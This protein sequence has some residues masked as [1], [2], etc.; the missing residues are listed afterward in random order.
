VATGTDRIER[1]GR[2]ARWLHAA[3]YLTTLAL[4]ATGLWLLGGQEGHPS[5][6]SRATGI[7]DTRLHIWL[8][9]ALTAVAALGLVAGVRAIPTFLRETFRYDRGDGRWFVR[10]PKAVF[11]G[12][13]GRHEGHWDPGQRIANV[14]M[15]VGLLLLTVTGVGLATLHGGHTFAFFA[16]V[17][18][19][20]AIGMTPVLLG[21]ILIA[22]G[23]LPGYKGVWRAMHLGGRLRWEDANRVWPGWAERDQPPVHVTNARVPEPASHH[24]IE[25]KE[26]PSGAA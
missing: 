2:R 18:K 4:L 14:V 21:H 5:I 22:A 24:S 15:V 20:T 8:G 26:R 17:H 13:F 12:R 16:K 1:Y 11:T 9:W 3:V 25:T 23:V 6:L 19:W 10:W 7:A